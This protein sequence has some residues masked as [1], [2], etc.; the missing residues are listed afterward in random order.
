ME[1]TL[2]GQFITVE[3]VEG[4]GKTTNLAFIANYLQRA[5]V[6]VLLTREP[7]GTPLAEQLR[8]LLLADR[9]EVVDA[10]AELL[11]IFAAR[12]QHF[13][14][15]IQPALERG[16]WVLCDRFTDATY[17][18]QGGGRG[19]PLD[20]IEQLELMVQK[21]R[22]PDRTFFLDVDVAVGLARA[23]SRGALD[24]FEQESRQFFDAVRDAYWQRVRQSPQRFTIIDAGNT[25]PDVEQQL[26][27]ALQQLLQQTGWQGD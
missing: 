12:A 13:N 4:C 21:G 23:G 2:A 11:M 19:L 14:R 18:Y 15:V 17:A 27:Q 5:G 8:E 24:R 10:Q 1:R 6:P 9:Q 3:G 20:L 26:A 25:L 16:Q 22:Q 7:G